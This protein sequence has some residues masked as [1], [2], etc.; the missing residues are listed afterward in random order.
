MPGVLAGTCRPHS[1]SSS[2]TCDR[3]RRRSRRPSA[4]LRSS[5]RS[6]RLS[7][8]A[9]DPSAGPPASEIRAPARRLPSST[10]ST[11]RR[12][13]P[14]PGRARDVA[15]RLR[16]EAT[17]RS[18][19]D[20]R[21]PAGHVPVGNMAGRSPRQT[22]MDLSSR[23]GGRGGRR[24]P[25]AGDRPPRHLGLSR[26]ETYGL[27]GRSGSSDPPGTSGRGLLDTALRSAIRT[28]AGPAAPTSGSR[29]RARRG[30]V[31]AFSSSVGASGRASGVSGRGRF[32]HDR[33]RRGRRRSSPRPVVG[34]PS[35]DAGFGIRSLIAWTTAA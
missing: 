33:L 28:W 23:L 31:A 21:E 22:E 3:V 32:G 9:S 29:R 34:S 6:G 11:R 24:R 2:A 14:S 5:R 25:R 1:Q 27:R 7:A 15:S 16:R 13:S 8:M 18:V 30:R 35:L 20:E 10:K 26:V 12:A 4:R 17:A 19:G